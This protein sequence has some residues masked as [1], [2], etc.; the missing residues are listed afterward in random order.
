[1][2]LQL[3]LIS[4][5]N[6]STMS[7]DIDISVVDASG[8][9]SAEKLRPAST[10]QRLSQILNHVQR[11]TRDHPTPHQNNI[12]V[13]VVTTPCSDVFCDKPMSQTR[14]MAVGN[15]K[16]GPQ[17]QLVR[18]AY[19]VSSDNLTMAERLEK[20]GW[21]T[22]RLARLWAKGRPHSEVRTQY[23]RSTVIM[24]VRRCWYCVSSWLHLPLSATPH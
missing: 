7:Q 9:P 11:L 5:S 14:T 20:M 19:E 3:T 8:F 21:E 15:S 2:W 6:D 24:Q 18:W 23:E 12:A 13:D 17:H 4:P 10:S 1:M 16:K 22:G